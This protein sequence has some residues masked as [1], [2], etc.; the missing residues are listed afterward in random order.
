LKN[1]GDSDSGM[2][3]QPPANFHQ[4]SSRKISSSVLNQS[5]SCGV[6]HGSHSAKGHGNK[7]E[8]RAVGAGPLMRA[9]CLTPL[10]A[11][12]FPWASPLGALRSV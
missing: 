8:V 7:A 3:M 5:Y 12:Q 9:A 6:Y 2:A 4:L 10:S 11:F 1:V